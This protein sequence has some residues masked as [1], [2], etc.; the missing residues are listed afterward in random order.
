MQQELHFLYGPTVPG[1]LLHFRVYRN[2]A[3]GS[4]TLTSPIL[5]L[6]APV[7]PGILVPANGITAVVNNVPLRNCGIPR[8]G[9]FAILAT[10]ELTALPSDTS[11]PIFGSGGASLELLTSCD[12]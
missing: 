11:V 3:P 2:I 4:E 5:D 6:F 10:F 9:P 1:V 7:P 12:T 8:G